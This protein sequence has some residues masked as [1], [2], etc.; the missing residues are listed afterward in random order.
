MEALDHGERE[1]FASHLARCGI[2]RRLVGEFQTVATLLPETLDVEPAPPGL[3][4]RIL[5]QAATEAAPSVV[6]IE[7]GLPERK[8]VGF[9]ASPVPVAIAALLLIV[10]GLLAW[11]V[12]LQLGDGDG[13]TAEQRQLLD[14]IASGAPIHEVRGTE[15]APDARARLV[16]DPSGETAFLLVHNLPSLPPGM[17]FQ[18]WS[19]ADNTPVGAGTFSAP[20]DAERPVVLH[21]DFS[22]ADAIGISI[23]PIGGSA[24]PTA[25]RIVLLGALLPP[26]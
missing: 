24:A 16:Q 6:P 18:A 26:F 4:Q 10:I 5:S 21:A 20:E 17:E 3:K 7:R 12:I 11:N 13:L 19:I 15:A 2:C 8:R 22:E 23:E 9:W 25:E 1:D 14:A